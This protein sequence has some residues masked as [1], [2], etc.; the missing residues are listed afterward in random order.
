LKRGGGGGGTI[1]LV[2][3]QTYEFTAYTNKQHDKKNHRIVK[4]KA[5]NVISL[6]RNLPPG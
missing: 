2:G 6:T 3:P 1:F 5:R 4:M